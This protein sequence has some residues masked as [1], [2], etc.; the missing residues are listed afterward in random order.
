MRF[1]EFLTEGLAKKTYRKDRL[2]LHIERWVEQSPHRTV[3][4]NKNEIDV[5]LSLAAAD[6]QEEKIQKHLNQLAGKEKVD[7]KF[8]YVDGDD[9]PDAVII[10]TISA[11]NF[12][13]LKFLETV[14]GP[15]PYD[16]DEEGEY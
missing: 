3:G 6:E 11:M 9:V 14:E 15:S 7:W 16:E 12:R 13:V 1:V 4:W 8:R 2:P 5:T 10:K